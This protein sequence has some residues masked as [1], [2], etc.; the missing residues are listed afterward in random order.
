MIS[1][2][3]VVQ[4]LLEIFSHKGIEQVIVSPGSRNAPLVQTFKGMG[5]FEMYSVPDERTAGFLAL[6]MAMRLRRPV[7]LTCTSGSAL[8]NYGPAIAEAYYQNIPLIVLSADRPA[9]LID[10]G[11]GQSIRQNEVFRNYIKASLD[12]EETS[13]REAWYFDSKINEVLAHTSGEDE[14]PVHINLHLEEPL[15]EFV[16]AKPARARTINYPIFEKSLQTGTMTRLRKVWTDSQKVMILVG[17]HPPRHRLNAWLKHMSTQK[18]IV[19]L[20]EHTSNV[21]GDFFRVNHIDRCIFP[22]NQAE[23]E[24]YQPDLLITFGKEIVSKK[25]KNVLLRSTGFDHWHVGKNVDHRDT[26]GALTEILRIP[27]DRFLEGIREFGTKKPDYQNIWK[28]R[29]ENAENIHRHYIAGAQWS[30]LKAWHF[31]SRHVPTPLV[32]HLGNSATV[33]YSLLFDLPQE[34]DFYSNRGVSG[35]EGCTS[36]SLGFALQENEVPV[37]LVCGDLTFLYDLNAFWQTPIPKSYKIIVLNNRGGGIFRFI[38]GP[39]QSSV[40]DPFLETPHQESV[41]TAIR[42][43]EIECFSVNNYT[44]L[45]E[46]FP[47][48]AKTPRMAVLE[49]NTPRMQNDQILKAYFEKLKTK[50]E[51]PDLEKD[52]SA[53]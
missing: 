44:E 49:I 6:G 7:V 14:G 16:K 39:L 22:L 13:S 33:R 27:P 51:N 17:Q 38:E 28:M 18:N 32:F 52:S 45:Q 41:L 15:Y 2:K 26:F 23:W 19:I 30:D 50:H 24:R 9:Y 5:N 42:N 1:N 25:I 36:T 31:L 11:H 8:L 37:W 29:V 35:I 48:F 43:P 46:I 40:A 47:K 34:I 21:K 12:I 20:S 53:Q 4:R 3:E 10:Q